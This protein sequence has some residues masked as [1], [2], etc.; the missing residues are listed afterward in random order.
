MEAAVV[1]VPASAIWPSLDVTGTVSIGCFV[2]NRSRRPGHH[3]LSVRRSGLVLQGYNNRP[4]VRGP[5]GGD[6]DVLWQIVFD[7]GGPV[8]QRGRRRIVSTEVAVD[9]EFS[10]DPVE[11]DPQQNVHIDGRPS[12]YRDRNDDAYI[13][14]MAHRQRA[15]S[16]RVTTRFGL[17]CGIADPNAGG[18]HVDG[19]PLDV[20]GAILLAVTPVPVGNP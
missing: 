1:A 7:V 4:L 5:T 2:R 8:D 16:D 11:T 19:L 13:E 17:K 20:R 10:Y 9:W 14:T 15:R 3:R 12:R 6:I 18:A